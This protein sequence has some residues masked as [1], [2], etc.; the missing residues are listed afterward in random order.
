MTETGKCINVGHLSK[1]CN[2]DCTQFGWSDCNSNRAC[3]KWRSPFECKAT[4]TG[5][6][7]G[8]LTIGDAKSCASACQTV[9]YTV[10]TEPPYKGCKC[11]IACSINGGTP[12][13]WGGGGGGSPK[14]PPPWSLIIGIS[15][16]V[17]IFIILGYFYVYRRRKN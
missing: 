11:D 3:C 5:P 7:C 9:E 4:C 12:S 2:Q 8:S 14:T 15:V 17:L 10:T 1:T 16:S 13:P 6:N